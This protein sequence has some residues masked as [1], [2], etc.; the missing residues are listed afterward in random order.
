MPI[1]VIPLAILVLFDKS[2][3]LI[4]YYQTYLRHSNIF[5]SNVKVDPVREKLE[6]QN[7]CN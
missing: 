3:S 2:S 5:V 1:M 7:G 4:L 6:L